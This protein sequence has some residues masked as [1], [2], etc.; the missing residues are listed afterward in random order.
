MSSFGSKIKIDRYIHSRLKYCDAGLQ[1]PKIKGWVV[2]GGTVPSGAS[3]LNPSLRGKKITIDTQDDSI[4]IQDLFDVEIIEFVHRCDGQKVLVPSFDATT[5]RCFVHGRS[6]GEQCAGESTIRRGIMEIN[7]ENGAYD[8]QDRLALAQDSFESVFEIDKGGTMYAGNNGVGLILHDIEYNLIDTYNLTS[9]GGRIFDFGVNPRGDVII[10]E[11]TTQAPE[12]ISQD[13]QTRFTIAHE[14]L[15]GAPSQWRSIRLSNEVIYLADVNDNL[16]AIDIA[17]QN[18][19][20]TKLIGSYR[21]HA[22]DFEGNLIIG[23]NPS[24][25]GWMMKADSSDGSTIFNVQVSDSLT[26]SP[27]IT[28]VGILSPQYYYSFAGVTGTLYIVK[29][30]GTV[31]EGNTGLGRGNLGIHP[32]SNFHI[33]NFQI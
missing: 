13:K 25:E 2:G 23:R 26:T 20:W 3:F 21:C 18:V 29:N 9:P 11:S 17:T 4:S 31:L 33:Q 27:S 24:T 22:L 7:P 6:S 12:F 14:S 8:S 1:F 30:D 28:Q 19:L 5:E 16:H 10:G 32:F 15:P